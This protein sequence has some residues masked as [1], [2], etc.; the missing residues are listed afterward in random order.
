MQ[1]PTIF[2]QNEPIQPTRQAPQR[3]GPPDRPGRRTTSAVFSPN[4][5]PSPADACLLLLRAGDIE[6]NARPHCCAY[7]NLVRHGTSPLRYSRRTPTYYILQ[8][9]LRARCA[10][11]SRKHWNIGCRGTQI[12]ISSGNTPMVV[13]H[14]NS[15][16][17]RPTP[18]RCWLSLGSPSIALGA[19]LNNNNNNCACIF[20]VR[21]TASILCV[22]NLGA[23]AGSRGSCVIIH[24]KKP[25]AILDQL[26]VTE[27]GPY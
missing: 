13:L 6:T 4:G 24:L 3:L 19:R 14:P 25:G 22:G 23:T 2:S 7:G 8:P 10:R 17:S 18:R 5:G 26:R 16:S 9:T 20:C 21:I 11:R 1:P 27:T 15:E 12:S